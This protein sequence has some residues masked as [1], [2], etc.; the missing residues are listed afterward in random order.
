M[1]FKNEL[2]ALG[3]LAALFAAPAQAAVVT[4]DGR[5]DNVLASDGFSGGCAAQ[6]SVDLSSEGLDCQG[7]W[8]TL[9]CAADGE[10]ERQDGRRMFDS[11]LLAFSLGKRVKVWVD[12]ATK[13]DGR[14]YGNRV[15]VF[16]N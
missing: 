16:R 15:D 6:L 13:I 9:N 14:C 12:D 8:V 10:A 7:S 2:G 4:V 3:L 5:I 11:A 1:K